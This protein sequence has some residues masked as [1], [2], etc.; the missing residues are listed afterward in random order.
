MRPYTTSV[1]GLKL[2]VYGAL[3]TALILQHLKPPC[4]RTGTTTVAR[5][6]RECDYVWVK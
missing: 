3:S 2:L 1:W 6:T 5:P 4:H